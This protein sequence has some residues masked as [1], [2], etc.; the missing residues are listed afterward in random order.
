MF[1]TQIR[2]DTNGVLDN[3]PSSKSPKF[4]NLSLT[5]STT[6]QVSDPQSLVDGSADDSRPKRDIPE[7]FLLP[8]GY[9]DV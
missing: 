1:H 6:S 2:D 8:N 4:S 7:A 3:K 9:P 5:E